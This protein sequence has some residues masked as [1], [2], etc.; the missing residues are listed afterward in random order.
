MQSG[1]V[2]N[3]KSNSYCTESGIIKLQFVF[4]FLKIQVIIFSFIIDYIDY[5]HG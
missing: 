1:F 4:N 3:L 5:K 2:N